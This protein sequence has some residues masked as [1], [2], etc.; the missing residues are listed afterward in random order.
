MKCG[1]RVTKDDP[2]VSKSNIPTVER[3][4]KSP[5]SGT[6][7]GRLSPPQQLRQLGEVHRQPARLVPGQ[8]LGRR[9]PTGLVREVKI[10][11]RLAG[12]D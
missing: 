3:P 4:H 6:Q 8:Q 2:V 12:R 11:E 5:I 10:A 1:G 9:A 7:G